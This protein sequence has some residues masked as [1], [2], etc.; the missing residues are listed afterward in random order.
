MEIV[1]LSSDTA[2]EQ[3]FIPYLDAV[4]CKDR[5]LNL[6]LFS[7]SVYSAGSVHTLPEEHLFYFLLDVRGR[8]DA[9]SLIKHVQCT[10]SPCRL[11]LVTDNDRSFCSLCNRLFPLFG[12]INFTQ[13]DWPKETRLLLHALNSSV[14]QINDGLM[15][16]IGRERRLIPYAEICFIETLKGSHYCKIQKKD[17]LSYIIRANIRDLSLLMDERFFPVRSSTIAN[18]SLVSRIDL[19]ERLLFFS[20]GSTCQYAQVNQAV[21]LSRIDMFRT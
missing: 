3:K 9:L 5:L 16:T 1:V 17:S 8:S 11:G 21:I 15:I 6:S 12:H 18:L 20:S 10:R 4:I 13:P 2:L 19:S 7:N 14:L